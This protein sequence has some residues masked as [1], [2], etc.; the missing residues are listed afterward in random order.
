M[1]KHFGLDEHVK[2]MVYSLLT[3]KSVWSRIVPYLPSIDRVFHNYDPEYIK[4]QEP[5]IFSEEIFAMKFGNM[6]TR[7]QMR[8]LK[9]NIEILEQV[10]TEYGSVD[11]YITGTDV[12]EVV[13]SF[14]KTGSKY[15]LGMMGEALVWEY[16]RNVGIDGVKPDTHIRRFLSGNRIGEPMVQSPASM[17]DVYR[18]VDK[19]SKKTGLLKAEI[20]NLIWS[21]CAEG[22]GEICTANPHCERCPIKSMCQR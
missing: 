13:E 19:L 21:F 16:L 10:E 2:A 18:H 11:A 15:K 22:Y 9:G 5:D 17:E 8:A 12:K 6:S 7:K 1:G 3:N 14:S 20:D 4:G